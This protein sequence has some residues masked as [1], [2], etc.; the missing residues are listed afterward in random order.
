M[1]A[2]PCFTPSLGAGDQSTASTPW[3]PVGRDAS[4][5]APT[6]LSF[7]GRIR[8]SMNVPASPETATASVTVYGLALAAIMPPARDAATPRL[9]FV[10]E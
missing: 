4:R 7:T 3:N 5:G 9:V 2:S 10:P 1:V 8:C 6:V